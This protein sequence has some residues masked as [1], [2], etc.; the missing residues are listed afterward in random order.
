MT[1]P[2]KPKTKSKRKPPARVSSKANQKPAVKKP[3]R[4]KELRP[5]GPAYELTE[6]K[7]VATAPAESSEDEVL[8]KVMEMTP[9]QTVTP[10]D[11]VTPAEP[12]PALE[13]PAGPLTAEPV[14]EPEREPELEKPQPVLKASEPV[15]QAGPPNQ[16]QAAR[17]APVKA[18]GQ[19]RRRKRILISLL[20]AAIIAGIAGYLLMQHRPGDVDTQLV[21]QVAKLAVLPSDEEPTVT[22]V[23]D[24][25]KINQSF[26]A[27]AREGDKVLLYFQSGKAVVY[28]PSSRQIVNMGPLTQPPAQVFIRNGTESETLP[29]SVA[30][31]LSP[32]TSYNIISRDMA[33]RR[34]Y[35]ET[36]VVDL[37]GNRPDVATRVATALNAKVSGLP[38]GET[39]PEGD[40]LIIVGKDIR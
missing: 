32:P 5:A 7:P 26:L 12:E 23:V 22:T 19:A 27:N 25:S 9:P 30:D 39:R 11:T 29:T 2:V 21:A 6:I 20:F 31:R 40:I 35:T 16:A 37:A 28:R 3:K 18:A 36:I 8:P 13:E 24:K 1:A 14:Q 34:D 17:T 38:E 4:I 33:A 15:S 10:P